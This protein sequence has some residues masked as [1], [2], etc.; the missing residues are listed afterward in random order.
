MCF[1]SL[2]FLQTPQRTV[3]GIQLGQFLTSFCIVQQEQ[4]ISFH[5]RLSLISAQYIYHSSPSNDLPNQFC[6]THQLQAL[7]SHHLAKYIHC[8]NL[9]AIA[10]TAQEQHAVYNLIDV[11]VFYSLHEARMHKWVQTSTKTTLIMK[12]WFRAQ[13]WER[14]HLSFTTT[15]P[16][17]KD[18]PVNSTDTRKSCPQSK[19]Y[20]GMKSFIMKFRQSS[21]C[22]KVL[23][24]SAFFTPN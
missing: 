4:A 13:Q 1:N 11:P 9:L 2:V 23:K 15:G 16:T 6:T 12:I 20:P 14:N 18:K 8:R 19:N 10:S 21:P 24:P 5:C 7:L 3:Q 22:S 17:A